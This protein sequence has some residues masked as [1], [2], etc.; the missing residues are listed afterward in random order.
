[1]DF[2]YLGKVHRAGTVDGELGIEIDLSPDANHQLITRAE[3]VVGSDI[4][5]AQ[6]G[7]GRGDLA[8]ETITVDRKQRAQ[9][10]WTISWNSVGAEGARTASR[11]DSSS[12]SN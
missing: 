2:A 3:D 10:A 5:L 1:M 11:R 4:D 12:A 7:K 9:G 6:R 8:K